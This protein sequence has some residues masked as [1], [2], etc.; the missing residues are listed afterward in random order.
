MKQSGLDKDVLPVDPEENRQYTRFDQLNPEWWRRLANLTAA[1]DGLIFDQVRVVG[2]A[3]EM[4]WFNRV[5]RLEPENLSLTYLTGRGPQPTYQDGLAAL[6][7]LNYLAA[8]R[9]LPAPMGLLTEHHLVGGTTFFRGPHVMAAVRVARHYSRAGDRFLESGR[10][11]GGEPA[12]YG[13]YGISF[14]IF[15]GI[16]W[17]V[18]LWEED[19]EFPARAQYL[20]DKNLE[21]IFPLDVI[22]ALGNVVAAKMLNSG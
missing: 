22:W 15:P 6:V 5:L 20:F 2:A 7:L 12:A 13:E 14:R 17:I 19:E 16:E 11:W 3:L 10:N 8:H 1:P 18:A 9:C 4:P 21:K